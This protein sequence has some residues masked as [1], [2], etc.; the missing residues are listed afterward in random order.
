MGCR[1][2]RGNQTMK[3][4]A[5]ITVVGVLSFLAPAFA[6][7]ARSGT[8]PDPCALVTPAEVS[9]VL[10]LKIDAGNRVRPTFCDWAPPQGGGKRVTL[11][12]EDEKWFEGAKRQLPG[13]ISTTV[14]GVGDDAIS[15]TVGNFTT[16]TVKKGAIVFVVR[17]YGFP[18]EEAK[19]KEK[20]IAVKAAGRL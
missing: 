1:S 19:E 17:M 16:L 10:G 18:V 7:Q 6:R 5:A 8:P 15:A 14:S 12:L 3:S 20:A 9:A 13:V 2:P 4:T 11:V